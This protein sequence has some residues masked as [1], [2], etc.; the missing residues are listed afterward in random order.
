MK[1]NIYLF[2]N[3]GFKTFYALRPVVSDVSGDFINDNHALLI[4]LYDKRFG[5]Q[6]Y[7]CSVEEY[8]AILMGGTKYD[9]I[10]NPGLYKGSERNVIVIVNQLPPGT[11]LFTDPAPGFKQSKNFTDS[12]DAAD[13][14]TGD[15]VIEDK[16]I[17]ARIGRNDQGSIGYT[18]KNKRLLE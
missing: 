11:Y 5:R 9:V 15:E 6:T 7:V 18:N 10:Y 17:Y 4:R 13:K 16:T 1:N 8:K 2:E 12:I 3:K 14:Q